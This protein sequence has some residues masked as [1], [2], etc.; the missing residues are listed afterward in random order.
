[1]SFDWIIRG[2]ALIDG[3]GG[4][5][6]RADV[7]IVGRQIAAIG[8]LGENGRTIDAIGQ[9]VCPGFV[10]IHSH[11]DFTLMLNRPASSAVHQGVTTEVVGN[12]GISFAPASGESVRTLMPHYTRELDVSWRTFDQYL[13]RLADPGL[14]ENV[15]HLVGNGA[16]RLAVLGFENR[17][18]TPAELATMETLVEEAMEAG[19][20]GLSIGLEYPPG[21]IASRDELVALCRVVARRGG[22]YA[23]HMRNQDGGYF[24][25]IRE[26]LD[27]TEQ[28][29]ARLQISHLPPHH[30][31]TPPGAAEM[32]IELIHDAACRG[33][34]VN[35]DVHPYLWGLTFPTALLPVGALEGGPGRLL[36]RLD[37]PAFRQAVRDNPNALPQHLRQGH[38][39]KI[40]LRYAERSPQWIGKSVAEI[41]ADVGEDAY[42]AVFELMRAESDGFAGMMWIVDL[43]DEDDL[44][45][46]LRQPEC[47]VAADG[48]ALA[49]D[50]PLARVG[51]HP[52][53]FGWTARLLARYV[54]DEAVL[55]LPEAIAKM[56]GRPAAKARLDNRG[57]VRDGAP[58]DLVVFD[59]AGLRDNATY[60][61][62]NA[63]P[64]GFTH[65]FVNGQRVME[66]GRQ[67]GGLPG[68]VIRA[69]RS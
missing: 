11:S 56:T 34:D 16:V 64:D 19:A 49:T 36:E 39:E 4:P 18:P 26:A 65:V 41:A 55:T 12:C 3:T 21:N 9:Y 46:L 40:V 8:D 44:K 23:I 15:A 59:L 63:Y 1:M 25:A 52:R 17:P 13:N 60:Q 53:C 42:D 67:H 57:L 37:D 62:P 28:S 5:V 50:G 7:G 33:V 10:D 27:I 2:G 6:R 29:G 51:M 48:M 24:D 47:F 68:E 14:A 69:G 20:I 35:F 43:V 31:S 38:H 58:A 61:E 32:A 45:F 22:L 66:H 54:R 30:D